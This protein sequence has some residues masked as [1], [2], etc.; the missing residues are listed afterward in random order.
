M[1]LSPELREALKV[2]GAIEGRS[3]TSIIEEAA[4][5]YLEDKGGKQLQNQRIDR[6][7][8]AAGQVS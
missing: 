1:Y 8:R 7:L 5:H 4:W 2:R 3:A 6:L